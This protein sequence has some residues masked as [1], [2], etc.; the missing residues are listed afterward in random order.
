MKL[1][2]NITFLIQ[3]DRTLI[4]IKDDDA[5]TVFCRIVLTPEQT[6]TILSH[7]AMVE[8]ELDVRGLDLV[9][10]THENKY[11]EFEIPPELI[12]YDYKRR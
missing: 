5:S 7:Q 3:C 4:E 1:K 10:K 2:G 8:C 9:G 12:G 6:I 11:F